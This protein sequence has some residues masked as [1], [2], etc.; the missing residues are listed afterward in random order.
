ML[1]VSHSHIPNSERVTL[2]VNNIIT[3]VKNINY[4]I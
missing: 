4:N 3:E 2:H 1:K